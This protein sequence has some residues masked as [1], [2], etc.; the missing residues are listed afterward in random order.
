MIR[1][2]ESNLPDEVIKK[3]VDFAKDR[4]GSKIDL[5]NHVI[6]IPFSKD[7]TE[8]DLM[9]DGMLGKWFTDNGFKI[10]FSRGD[11]DYTTQDKF[12]SRSMNRTRGQKAYLRDR[13]I[14][15]ITW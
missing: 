6:V 1:V 14:G 7:I 4:K 15:T 11:V 13:L 10:E 2:I 8:D 5:D 9:S 12:N 3:A